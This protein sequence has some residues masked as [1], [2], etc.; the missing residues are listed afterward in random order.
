MRQVIHGGLIALQLVVAL[1][2]AAQEVAGGLEQIVVTGTRI[3]RPDFES[4][5]PIISITAD[6]FERTSASSV[7]TVVS[8]LPQ[9]TPDATSTSNN[10]GNGGQGNVQMRGLGPTSTL[11]LLDGRRLVPANGNGVVDVNVIPPALVESVEV[12]SGG[13][14]AV[15]GSDAIAGVVNFKLK[16]KFEGLQFDGG[17]AGT[18]QGD[19]TEY[20][21][22]V[23]GGLSFGD[24]RGEAF[25]YVGY[26]EREAVF[27]RARK[28]SQA[29]LSYQGPGAGGVGPDGGFLPSGSP[30]IPEGRSLFPSNRPTQAAIDALFASYGYAA[31]TV[32]LPANGLAFNTDGSVFSTGDGTPGT[33]ANFRGEQDPILYNDRDYSYNYGPWNYLQLPLERTSV[34][35]RAAF[36]VSPAAELY[37]QAL[38]SDYTAERA[39]A[40]TA[41]FPLFVPRSN[42]YIPVDFGILLDSRPNPTAPFRMAKRLVELG[43]R[44]AS[45]QHDVLQATLGSTGRILDA[46]NYDA[47]VQTGRYESTE[48]QSGNALRSKIEELTFAPDGGVA[49][50]GGLD[51]FGLNSISDE[52]AAYIAA[53]G[54]NRSHYDQTIAEASISGTAFSLPAGDLKVAVGVL[55]KRDEYV[56]EADPIGSVVLDDGSID[57]VGFNA[58]DDIDGSDHNVDIYAE[59]A[60]PLLAG[61]TGIER[62]ETVLGYRHSEYESAGGVDSYK[63]ELLYNPV[64]RLTLR[65]SYQHAVRAPSVFELYQPQL[66]LTYLDMRDDGSPLDP[67]DATSLERNGPHVIAVEALCLAQ[68]VPAALLPGFADSDGI[69]PAV[70]GGNPDLEPETAD[71]WTVGFV[72][73]SWSAHPLLSS[74]H[75]SLDWYSIDMQDAIV[76]TF[77]ND[78]VPWCFDARVNPSFD[79]S[80]A[81]CGQFS[82]DP[83]TG[84][85]IDL[86][87]INQNIVGYE[88]SGIDAQFDWS[89]AAGPGDVGFNWLV[90][91]MDSF[92]SVQVQGLS[93]V[94]EVGYVGGFLGGSFPEWKWN[95][96]LSYAWGGLTVAGQWRYVDG[97]SDRNWDYSMSSQDYLDLFAGYEFGAGMLSGMTLRGGIENLMD[98]DPP[99]IPTQVAANTDPSQ[100]DVMGRRYY[101][102][103]S[104]RF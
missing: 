24:G 102:S 91:W 70:G 95:L 101:V 28:F 50:C 15:Y 73:S 48:S 23:T 92:E 39:L 33:V 72:L 1:P 65:S 31:G 12:I 52:C 43:P 59:A 54:T 53:G 14:S 9:F 58:S 67:C 38:Y 69:M 41:A 64:Q 97:M 18:D 51:L 87:D 17:W 83:A 19:G 8:R 34:F 62:L 103:L 57:I 98:D 71:T 27:Q 104:Y 96:N 88:V 7:E 35:A 93:P 37:G 75:L 82:R 77:A 45:D 74:M 11:V 84:E 80:N 66:P 94:D 61:L 56:Y 76:D 20:T 21:A 90:S 81:Q 4:A 89:F 22:G 25:G 30:F 26:S 85:I 2:V 44:L 100:Y 29:V 78:Y 86:Q 32:R 99:L 6:A 40:P 60:V 42:P 46:W 36:E 13:A 16:D 55:Y 47:Y 68:G 79:V 10:P 5:S 63:A 3:A 49:A